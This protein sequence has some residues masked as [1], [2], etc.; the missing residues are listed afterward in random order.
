M[1]D[2]QHA[3]LHQHPRAPD[4]LDAAS[5]ESGALSFVAP[6]ST[7]ADDF[8]A[9]MVDDLA[10]FDAELL[11]AEGPDALT[12]DRALRLAAFRQQQAVQHQRELAEAE[13]DSDLVGYV[14]AVFRRQRGWSAEALADWLGISPDDYARLASETRP[15]YVQYTP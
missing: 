6:G 9:A 1:H 2:E 8:D 15:L 3:D 4:D 7:E 11:A 13:R 10:A 5:E 14:L 12:S